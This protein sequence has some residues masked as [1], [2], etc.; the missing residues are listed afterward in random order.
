MRE[1]E[2][3]DCPWIIAYDISIYQFRNDKGEEM[4]ICHYVDDVLIG[5]NKA[6]L[7]DKML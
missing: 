2:S 4:L 7:K 6:S 1:S 3:A 5:F